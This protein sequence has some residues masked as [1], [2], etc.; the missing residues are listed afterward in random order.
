MHGPVYVTFG[1]M[2]VFTN[3]LLSCISGMQLQ[4]MDNCIRFNEG[5]NA[6]YL[7]TILVLCGHFLLIINLY[8]MT[9]LIV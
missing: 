9:H 7:I 8:F 4:S 3:W 6:G 2:K 5:L 1:T